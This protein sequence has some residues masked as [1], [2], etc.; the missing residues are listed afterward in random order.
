MGADCIFIATAP[1]DQLSNTSVLPRILP[2]D[3]ITE[4]DVAFFLALSDNMKVSEAMRELNRLETTNIDISED[5]FGASSR[6][7]QD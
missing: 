5:S 1:C 7:H 4:N 6:H 2:L 3:N